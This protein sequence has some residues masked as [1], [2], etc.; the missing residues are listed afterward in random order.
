M[1]NRPFKECKCSTCHKLTRQANGYCDDHQ[2]LAQ[3][4]EA[5]RQAYYD[6]YKRNKK[7]QKHYQSK[8]HKIW[9]KAIATKSNGLCVL[10]STVEAPTI[11]TEA[12]H[13]IPIETPEGWKRR[14]EIS[15][16]QWLCHSCHMK[17]TAQDKIKYS[18]KS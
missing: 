5:K 4:D 18:L 12:D 2:S 15:N 9:A 17:K 13:I 16:G 6:R 1:A 14:L 11:G 10:C 7:T 3:Q 8:E